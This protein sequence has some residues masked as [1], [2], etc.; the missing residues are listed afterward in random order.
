M[1]LNAADSVEDRILELQEKK[2][3]MVNA[4][5]GEGSENGQLGARLTLDDLHFLFG[6]K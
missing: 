2:R 3:R 4:A 6:L 1:F 5:V